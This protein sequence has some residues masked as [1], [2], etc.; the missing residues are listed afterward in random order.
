MMLI[1]VV[2]AAIDFAFGRLQAAIAGRIRRGIDGARKSVMKRRQGKTMPTADPD[3]PWAG[4]DEAT[5]AR[6]RAMAMPARKRAMAMPARALSAEA[7]LEKHG[8]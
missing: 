7:F 4:N 3:A 1:L 6:K 5:P 2:V 8:A